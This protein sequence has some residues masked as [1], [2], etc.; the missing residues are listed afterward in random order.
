MDNASAV[1]FRSQ[2]ALEETKKHY[3]LLGENFHNV[4]VGGFIDIPK[5]DKYRDGHNFLFISREFV[6]KGGLIVV[7][8]FQKVRDKNSES[9]IKK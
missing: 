5:A 1:F 3:G 6:P 8:A 9:R 4:G 2:W 7:E